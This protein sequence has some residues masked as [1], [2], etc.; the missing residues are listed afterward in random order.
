MGRQT[1]KVIAE[2]SFT[3]T[4]DTGLVINGATMLDLAGSFTTNAFM[5]E[6]IAAELPMTQICQN[7][8]KP[9]IQTFNFASTISR[10]PAT[11]SIRNPKPLIN[12]SIG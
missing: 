11:R 12:A 5:V 10:S 1:R 4:P 9:I 2:T 7:A 8:L 6:T 3:Y